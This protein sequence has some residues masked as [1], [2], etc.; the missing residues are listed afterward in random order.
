MTA[1]EIASALGA[2]LAVAAELVLPVFPVRADKRPA[3]PHGLRDATSDPAGIRELWRCWPGPL[4]D[5]CGE[6]R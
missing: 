4:V 2:A 6:R 3:C 1:A 5:G